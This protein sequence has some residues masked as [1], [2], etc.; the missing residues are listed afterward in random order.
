MVLALANSYPCQETKKH[1]ITG[2]NTLSCLG[3]PEKAAKKKN[4]LTET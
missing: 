3:K 4:S 1:I 2:L